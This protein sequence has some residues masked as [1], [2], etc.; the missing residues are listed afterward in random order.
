MN[1]DEYYKYKYQKYLNKL[2]KLKNQRLL[3]DGGAVK[4]YKC[5]KH[6]YSEM[7]EPTCSNGS[8][9][10]EIDGENVYEWS[11]LDFLKCSE[12]R[13]FYKQPKSFNISDSRT[14]IVGDVW[15]NKIQLD[16]DVRKVKEGDYNLFIY[17]IK[18]SKKSYIEPEFYI[19]MHNSY[20]KSDIKNME[21]VCKGTFGTDVANGGLY[22]K[23]FINDPDELKN[24]KIRG[25]DERPECEGV[26]NAWNTCKREIVSNEM[27]TI[28]PHGFYVG[29]CGDGGFRY[30]IAKDRI[31]GSMQVVGFGF[32]FC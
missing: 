14:V 31:E 28:L 19:A 25:S 22:D 24:I 2:S 16:G 6:Y 7:P 27:V 12:L 23:R 29:T 32:R 3:Q 18:D 17:K 4:K 20:K 30:W 1:A 11:L 13:Y 26:P 9:V 15:H 21:W 10:Y 5:G 8:I